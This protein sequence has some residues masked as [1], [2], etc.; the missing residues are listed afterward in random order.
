[1][2]TGRQWCRKLVTRDVRRQILSSGAVDP[3]RH[4]VVRSATL[5]A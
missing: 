4:G 2:D 3:P 5:F 1:V